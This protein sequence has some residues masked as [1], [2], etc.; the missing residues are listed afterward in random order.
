MIR[1]L[2]TGGAGFIGS[3]LADALIADGHDV[4][5]LDDLS[6]GRTEN[7]AH[8][9]DHPRFHL[10]VDS[11]LHHATINELVFKCDEVYRAESP[12]VAEQLLRYGYQPEGSTP[13]GLL[14]IN[15]DD[16]ALWRKLVADAKIP[17]D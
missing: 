17:L 7:V 11:V 12:E 4:W 3:H 8:L 14:A 9:L 13:E 16:L 6:T 15:R 10:V 2:V 5:A 1:T